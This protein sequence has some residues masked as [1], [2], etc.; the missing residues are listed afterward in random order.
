MTPDDVKEALD[1]ATTEQLIAELIKRPTWQGV[2]VGG[3]HKEKW[4]GQ[5]QFKFHFSYNTLDR[6]KAVGVLNLAAEKLRF[7]SGS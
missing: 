5:K 7:K 2:I 4:K 3:E 6:D 1:S